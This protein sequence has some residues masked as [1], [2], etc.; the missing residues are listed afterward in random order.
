MMSLLAEMK[1]N[2]ESGDGGKKNTS[3]KKRHIEYQVKN[4]NLHKIMKY[5]SW[6]HYNV[7]VPQ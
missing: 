7:L 5:F 4:Q 3:N 6:L 2:E 1:Q